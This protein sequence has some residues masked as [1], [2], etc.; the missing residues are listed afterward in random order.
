MWLQVKV[1]NVIPSVLGLHFTKAPQRAFDSTVVV[2]M[3]KALAAAVAVI[4]ATWLWRS[5]IDQTPSAFICG[6]E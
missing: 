4:V 5:H 2:I 1:T 3:V 6:K